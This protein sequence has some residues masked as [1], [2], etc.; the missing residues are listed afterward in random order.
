MSSKQEPIV[1]DIVRNQLWEGIMA[2]TYERI[3][4]VTEEQAYTLCCQLYRY[5]ANCSFAMAVLHTRVS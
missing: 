5:D 1:W 2:K 4:V 3:G